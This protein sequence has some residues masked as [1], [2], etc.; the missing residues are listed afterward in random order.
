LVVHFKIPDNSALILNELKIE[1]FRNLADCT[2]KFS[3]QGLIII[4]DNGQ[5]KTN[6]LEAIYFLT[7]VKSFRGK[8]DQD[9]I[10][11]GE[12]YFHLQGK[13]RDEQGQTERI[14]VGYD[15][16]RK[17]VLLSGNEKTKV[18]EAFGRFKS[19]LATPDDISIIQQAPALRRKYLDILL[20]IISPLY[21]EKLKSYKKALA[22]RNYLLRNNKANFNIIRPWEI[23][24]AETG[25]YLI[26][27]RFSAVRELSRIF[28]SIYERLGSSDK[29]SL[30]YRCNL[31]ERGLTEE[32]PGVERIRELFAARLNKNREVERSRGITLNGPQSDDLLFELKGRSL[33][34]YGSQGQQRTAVICLKMAE[35]KLLEKLKGSRPVLLLDDVFA[36]LDQKRSQSIV[37]ELIQGY[38]GF[39]TA[40][41]KE[42]VFRYLS[43][44]PVVFIR[45]GVISGS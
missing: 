11:F 35:A 10:R 34:L 27:E 33:K 9:C 8:S 29:G 24:M 22:A 12:K 42:A 41:R 36:E 4:G 32:T 39:V 45:N 40:P 21:L 13:W 37:E 25:A 26:R 1:K 20:S 14:S 2:L 28:G 23:Q 30:S 6:L 19:V 7:I 16:R 43:R 3:D 38:Q 15:G 5:G 18:S 17:K 31:F 44:L